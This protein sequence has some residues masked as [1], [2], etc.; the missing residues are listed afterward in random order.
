MSLSAAV[1]AELVAAGLSGEA[2]VS[3]CARIEAASP[4]NEGGAPR[5]ARQERNRRY[6]VSKRLKASYSDVSDAN[7]DGAPSLKDPVPNLVTVQVNQNPSPPIVPPLREKSD[8]KAVLAA[9][10]GVISSEQAAAVVEHRAKLRKPLTAHAA[11]L[12]AKSLSE[13]TDPTAA[14]NEMIERGWQSWKPGWG[15]GNG[16]RAPPHRQAKRNTA[17][18]GLDEL[19]RRFSENVQP[20]FLRIAG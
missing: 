5:T 20:S 9:F 16:S 12:L 2:L 1:V 3:A 17:L 11:S 14:A 7:S 10:D 13:A 18:D 6:Y 15:Q 8:R 19:E 4:V